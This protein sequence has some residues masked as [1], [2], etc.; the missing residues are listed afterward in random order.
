MPLGLTCKCL[1]PLNQ[2]MQAGCG[3]AAG[4]LAYLDEFQLA[5][6]DQPVDGGTGDAKFRLCCRNAVQKCLVRLL[7]GAG[8]ASSVAKDVWQRRCFHVFLR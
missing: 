4:A 3:D 6:L 2:G 1:V 8:V 5:F 7:W